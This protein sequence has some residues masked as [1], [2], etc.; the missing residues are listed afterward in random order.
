MADIG[1]HPPAP[2]IS[3][4]KTKTAHQTKTKNGSSSAC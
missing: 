4:P 1:P 3:R 2:R